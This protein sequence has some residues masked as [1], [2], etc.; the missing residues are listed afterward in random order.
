MTSSP[1]KVR[2]GGNRSCLKVLEV[3]SVPQCRLEVIA[4]RAYHFVAMWC[5]DGSSFSIDILDEQEEAVSGNDQL[6]KLALLGPRRKIER[7][8]L[9]SVEKPT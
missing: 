8:L 9:Y 5:R 6:P 3:L 2:R 1:D 4:Y 7:H